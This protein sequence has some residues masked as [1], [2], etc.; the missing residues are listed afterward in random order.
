MRK[1]KVL[2]FAADPLSAGRRTERLLLDEEVRQ[3]RRRI[4]SARYRDALDLDA[5]WATRT[6]DLLHAL[7][8]TQPRVVHFSGHGGPDGLV[9]SALDG[10]SGHPVG[11]AALAR[12]F[13]VFRGDIGLVVLN[14]CFS[15]PQAEAI[16]ARVGC[17]IGTRR[18]IGD[19][20]AITFSATFYQAL[21]FGTSVQ[22]AFDQARAALEMDHPEERECPE[23]VVRPD[24]DAAKLV[25]VAPGEADVDPAAAPVEGSRAS[26]RA[27]GARR[28]AMGAAAVLVLAA[29]GA[30]VRANLKD[31]APTDPGSPRPD[32]VLEDSVPPAPIQRVDSQIAPVPSPTTEPQT[33]AAEPRL[34]ASGVESDL[35]AARDLYRA[36]DYA[37]ARPLLE[38]AAAAGNTEA[39][40][41]LGIIYL[42]GW[43]TAARPKD[44]IPLLRQATAAGDA[45]ATNALGAAYKAGVGV[46]RD[47][48]EAMRL[49]RIAQEKG[50]AE[51]M[52][53]IGD[54][55]R[56]AWGVDRNYDSA[57]AWYRR[58]ARAGSPDGLMYVGSMY[59][60][61]LGVDRDMDEAVRWFRSAADAGSLPAMVRLGKMYADG[62][63]VRRDYEQARVLYQRAAD[64]GSAEGMYNLGVLYYHGHGVGQNRAEAIRRF[65][66]AAAAG[67][68]RAQA[69][70]DAIGAR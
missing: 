5:H 20:A 67:Y 18:E 48:D 41:Y 58:A 19:E 11:A 29:G 3:I 2:F 4:Q 51:A 13:E 46:D 39:M 42:N 68:A 22:A 35:A 43:G 66:Q 62:D 32:V 1:V 17:A 69:T 61:A 59:E 55:F 34:A 6:K 37:A 26:R 53:N 38:R 10:R 24:V 28:L 52:R 54:L 27:A 70:L 31:P 40:G 23:L 63:H 8:S 7:N 47:Y 33:Q 15:L 65:R 21:A 49:F 60:C 9:L 25:L 57:M 56:L 12:L 30:L 45:R 64:G 16:A 36:R 14:A 50:Y 44:A